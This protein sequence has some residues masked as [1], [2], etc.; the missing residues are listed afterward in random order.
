MSW[1]VITGASSGIGYAIAREFAKNG[2]DIVAAARNGKRLAELKEEFEKKYKIKVKTAV[3]DLAEPSSADRLYKMT[4]EE[5]LRVDYLVNDA[6]FGLRGDFLDTEFNVQQEMLTVN[7]LSTMKLCHLYGRDMC[8]NEMGR[9]LNLSSMSA[10]FAGPYMSV[11]YA[12]KAFVLSFSQALRE[13]L[14]GTGVTVTVLCPGPTDTEFEKRAKLNRSEMY[15][16]VKPKSA[17]YV[18]EAG[19]AGMMKGESVV[20][21]SAIVKASN[22]LTR[23][24][25]RKQAAV[26]AREI[27]EI[28]R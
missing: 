13:E 1:A 11:Y 26:L 3:L 23:L 15:K 27:N 6:G 22:I 2:T 19:Y 16:F 25:T 10:F 24:I 17:E 20:Y 18:A 9:I 5:G 28:R 21:G 12:A 4:S 7:V 14:R 8:S